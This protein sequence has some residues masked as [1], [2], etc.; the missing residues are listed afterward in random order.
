MCWSL[1]Q[2]SVLPKVE[3][4][5]KSKFINE[6]LTPELR[7]ALAVTLKQYKLAGKRGDKARA[8]IAKEVVAAVEKEHERRVRFNGDSTRSTCSRCLDRVI[9]GTVLKRE[10]IHCDASVG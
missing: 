6:V 2:V 9:G 3:P 10:G 4:T 1:A 8:Q 5:A 7:N